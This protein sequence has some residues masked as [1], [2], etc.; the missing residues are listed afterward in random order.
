[1]GSEAASCHMLSVMHN[2]GHIVNGC[3]VLSRSL[4]KFGFVSDVKRPASA[5]CH[6]ALLEPALCID[7]PRLLFGTHVAPCILFICFR[8]CLAAHAC[9]CRTHVDILKHAL[10]I[11]HWTHAQVGLHLRVPELRKLV[12]LDGA[13]ACMYDVCVQMLHHAGPTISAC[14]LNGLLLDYNIMHAN[15]LTRSVVVM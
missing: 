10:C 12:H 3:A 8:S 6:C 1:M 14:A 7:I 5:I 15:S 9:S 2:P 4:L 11:V 13:C